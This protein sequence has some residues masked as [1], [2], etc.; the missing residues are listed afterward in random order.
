MSPLLPSRTRPDLVFSNYGIA[1]CKVLLRKAFKDRFKSVQTTSV[2][3]YISNQLSAGER[4]F[5]SNPKHPARLGSC[6]ILSLG[7]L[8]HAFLN[9]NKL[10]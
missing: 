4:N 1:L 5:H 2:V 8:R 10:L 3:P 6:V 9:P 7:I